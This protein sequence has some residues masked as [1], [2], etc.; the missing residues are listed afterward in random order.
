MGGGG[1]LCDLARWVVRVFLRHLGKGATHGALWLDDADLAAQR[2]RGRARLALRSGIRLAGTGAGLH[3][4]RHGPV[5][6]VESRRRAAP[7]GGRDQGDL[8]RPAGH[9]RRVRHLVGRRVGAQPSDRV[10]TSA[11]A[12][13]HRRG[14]SRRTGGLGAPRRAAPAPLG[15]HRHRHHPGGVAG[16]PAAQQRP[17][18]H[19]GAARILVAAVGIV[20]ARADLHPPSVAHRAAAHAVVAGDRGGRGVGDGARPHHARR[21]VGTGRARARSPWRSSRSP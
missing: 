9:R 12:P 20:D 4:R 18:R 8:P 21:P 14:V 7:A 16:R 1:D 15:Q 2:A 19:V 6:H 10:R 13:A 5:A 11:A 17:R 3:P